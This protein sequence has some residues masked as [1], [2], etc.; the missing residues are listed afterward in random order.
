MKVFSHEKT[1]DLADA[2]WKALKYNRLGLLRKT[3]DL[4][5]AKW[6]ALK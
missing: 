4:A 1:Y 6:K 2:K 5:D 3:E